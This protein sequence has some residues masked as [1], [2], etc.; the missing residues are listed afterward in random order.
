MVN[1]SLMSRVTSK[2]LALARLRQHVI[3]VS[4]HGRVIISLKYIFHLENLLSLAGGGASC[5]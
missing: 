3:V 5:C 2:E 1:L 4:R